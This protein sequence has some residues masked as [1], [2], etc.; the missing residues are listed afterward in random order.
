MYSTAMSNKSYTTAYYNDDT[1]FGNKIQ[2]DTQLID[3]DT[4]A[5][6]TSSLEPR[7]RANEIE[8]FKHSV[9]IP[10]LDIRI[11]NNQFDIGQH[12][13]RLNSTEGLLDTLTDSLQLTDASNQT[14]INS[15]NGL[16]NRVNKL[17]DAKII[18]DPFQ[19]GNPFRVYKDRN[20]SLNYLNLLHVD[21]P[22]IIHPDIP[23]N[24]SIFTVTNF[25]IPGKVCDIVL[26]RDYVN[27][28]M[29]TSAMCHI[30][31]P[32]YIIANNIEYR[33]NIFT[34]ENTS[35]SYHEVLKSFYYIPP[36]ISLNGTLTK[37]IN[38]KHDIFVY[39]FG[40]NPVSNE[41]GKCF[42][43]AFRTVGPIIQLAK[44]N[45]YLEYQTDYFYSIDSTHDFRLLRQTAI[46]PG[47]PIVTKLAFIPHEY[48]IYSNLI[49]GQIGLGGTDQSLQTEVNNGSEG[50]MAV[51]RWLNYNVYF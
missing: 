20:P 46:R 42:N 1:L 41:L 35:R 24:R 7:V 17:I 27:G 11:R 23:G 18:Q 50:H 49:S 6:S 25:D 3:F 19:S 29:E 8:I 26:K 22:Y 36:G 45:H 15:Y 9:D 16:T 5:V 43:N 21:L 33:T 37:G 39:M 47:K 10:D 31:I 28:F 14:T 2:T 51:L 40:Y 38:D 4:L 30:P 13:A 48:D 12:G 44:M 32:Q 34:V